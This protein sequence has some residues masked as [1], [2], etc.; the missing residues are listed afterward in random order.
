MSSGPPILPPI[1]ASQGVKAAIQAIAVK[2]IT[3]PSS[4]EN[5][6]SPVRLRGEVTGQTDRG[7]VLVD[8]ER[9]LVELIL[10]DRQPL[11]R[12]TRIEIDVPAGRPP[13]SANIR[14][15]SSAQSSG[16]TQQKAPTVAQAIR[17]ESQQES[18]RLDRSP[19]Y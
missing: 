3:V 10:K 17:T 1:Q 15:D 18:T 19:P 4:L 14:P 12:G 6:S 13:Q 5:N 11:P 7:S 9:G 8:T 16:P 2:L